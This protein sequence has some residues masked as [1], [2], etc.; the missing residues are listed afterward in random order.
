M[1]VREENESKKKI[2][3]SFKFKSRENGDWNAL[4]IHVSLTKGNYSIILG[5]NIGM[6][7]EI[8]WKFKNSNS[9]GNLKREM[10]VGSVRHDARLYLSFI[11]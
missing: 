10:L 8:R 6:F 9:Q 11:P 2:V 4:Y 1:N 5:W 7:D 3:G